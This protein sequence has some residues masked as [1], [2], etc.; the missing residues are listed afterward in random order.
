ME[1]HHLQTFIIVADEQSITRAAKRLYSTPSTISMHIKALED[2]LGLDLF[3]RTNQG[4]SITA[5]GE[6]IREKAL[7]TLRAAQDLV[8][9]ATDLQ[10]TLIGTV[11]IGLC[12]DPPLLKIP[13]LIQHLHQDYPGIDLTLHQSTSAQIIDSLLTHQLDLG[14]VFGSVEQPLL[15]T[16]TLTEVELVVAIPAGW[17]S[18]VEASDWSQLATQ[19]WVSVGRACP[20]QLLIEAHLHNQGLVCRHRVQ[21][22]DDRSRYQLVQAGIGLSLLEREVAESGVEAGIL[23]IAPLPAL[24]CALSLVYRVHEQHQPV[25]RALRHIISALFSADS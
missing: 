13:A 11:A 22:D 25:V 9:H 18:T 6:Q 4:M 15:I 12:S 21:I 24:P 7:I 8:N 2:E 16:Q 23:R 20:F 1:L 17:S 3:T 10:H 19:P 14:F 5:I